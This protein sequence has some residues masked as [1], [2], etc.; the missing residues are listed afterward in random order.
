MM[1]K[2]EQNSPNSDLTRTTYPVIREILHIIKEA[3][4]GNISASNYDICMKDVKN[5]YNNK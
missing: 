2:N 4:N 5:I 1:P 3:F